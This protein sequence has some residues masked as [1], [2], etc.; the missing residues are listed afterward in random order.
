MKVALL[1]ASLGGGGAERVVLSLCEG[2]ND[3]AVDA[4]ILCMDN[5]KVLPHDNVKVHT[6]SSLQP[7]S[8]FTKCRMFFS[9]MTA[10]YKQAKHEQYTHFVAH[11]E[12]AN[13]ALLLCTILFPKLFPKH[14]CVYTAHN[15]LRSSIREKSRFKRLVATTL[16]TLLAKGRYPTVF[17]SKL[18]RQDALDHFGFT[19]ENTFVV[20]NF[21]PVTEIQRSASAPLPEQYS[22][23]QD[24]KVILAIG[25]LS[26]QKGHEYLIRSYALLCS[27]RKDTHLVI[28]GEGDRKNELQALVSQKGLDT[29]V[30]FL[31]FIDAPFN[32]MRHADVFVLPSLY[33]GMPMILLEAL[34]CSAAIVSTDCPSGPREVLA[35]KTPVDV[36]ARQ[37]EHHP[38]AILTPPFDVAASSQHAEQEFADAILLVINDETL[39]NQLRHEAKKRAEEYNIPTGTS[40]WLQLL[41]S[42]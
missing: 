41:R 1:I 8:V 10:L 11:M 18:A 40:R 20:P 12:R 19:R 26:T 7:T 21:V 28:L 23:L 17:V 33:E 30:S 37:V 35:P 2:L 15:H 14:R 42:L 25:R 27:K 24:K 36:T 6:L 3:C 29:D 38:C 32:W 16:Y 34:A 4:H 39:S 22:F 13:I 31:G 9:Q 5:D